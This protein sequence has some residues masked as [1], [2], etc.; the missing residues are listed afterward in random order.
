[1]KI[2]KQ[3][4]LE[5][6]E[7]ARLEFDDSQIDRFTSQFENIMKF[8]SKLDE[9]STDDITPTSHVLDVSTPLREDI[10]NNWLT[11]E[12]TLKNAPQSDSGFFTVP[13]II[14]D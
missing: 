5:V 7:L 9:L 10:V 14:E 4:V 8:I 12:E 3:D 13:K 11:Q 6:A 2:T 1:M